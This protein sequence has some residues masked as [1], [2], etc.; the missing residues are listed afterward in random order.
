LPEFKSKKR[1]VVDQ[2]AGYG[3][4]WTTQSETMEG[5]MTAEQTRPMNATEWA[6]LLA[7]SAIWGSSFFFFKVLVAEWPPFTV[8]LGRVGVAAIILNL[9]LVLRGSPMKRSLPWRQFLAMGTLNNVLPF[10]LIVW[11]ETRISSG[12]ASILNATTP[13]FAVIAAHFLTQSEKLTWARAVGVM[14]GVLGVVVLI[15][16]G[17]LQGVGSADIAG[18]GACLLAALSYAFAGIYGRRFRGLPSLQLATGQITCAAVVM[19][20]VAA[21]TDRFWTLPAPSPAVWGALACIAVLC[22]VLA[23]VLYFRL[24][25]TAGATNLLL[26]TFL[27]PVSALLLGTLALGEEIKPAAIAG[28]LLIGIGLI[29]IDG[30]ILKKLWP[31]AL[32]ART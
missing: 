32:V 30:R 26:V 3:L 18:E 2:A 31:R 10:S 20:P 17:V 8:V 9:F 23:Y 15:G 28:M 27:L 13:V 21:M 5:I 22:T 4:E 29:A 7:L 25:A 24:L 6:L 11:G 1:S 16:P 12:L 19:L 14:F